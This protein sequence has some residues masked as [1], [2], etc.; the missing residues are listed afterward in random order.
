MKKEVKLDFLNKNFKEYIAEGDKILHHSNI[1]K[2]IAFTFASLKALMLPFMIIVGLPFV[3]HELSVLSLQKKILSY[4]NKDYLFMLKSV[5]VIIIVS[6][7]YMYLKY[8]SMQYVVTSKGLYEIRGIFIKNY[9]YVPFTRITDTRI[10]RGMLDMICNT[11]SINV[12]T[13]GGTVISHGN[14]QP[15]EIRFAHVSDFKEINTIIN[16]Y[17]K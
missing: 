17:L 4:Y 13:A 7:I 10:H 15:Y 16:K 14:S 6:F 12:S 2:K 8:R 9:K 11:G 3:L 1:S 5:I